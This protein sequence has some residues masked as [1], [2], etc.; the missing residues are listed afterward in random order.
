MLLQELINRV[1][2]LL[3][4]RL[5]AQ[6]RT[7]YIAR[8]QGS[9]HAASLDTNALGLWALVESRRY[10]D[11]PLLEKLANYVADGNEGRGLRTHHSG[12]TK[13]SVY[14]MLALRQYDVARASA[15]PRLELT[16]TETGSGSVLLRQQF[17]AAGLPPVRYRS[18]W[19]AFA[20]PQDPNLEFRAVGAGEASV[21]VALEFVPKQT[22]ASP[23]YLGL[24]VEK[25]IVVLNGTDGTGVPYAPETRLRPGASPSRPS[26]P[27]V[28]AP[29]AL[30]VPRDAAGFAAP[31]GLPP[32]GAST[33]PSSSPWS[34]TKG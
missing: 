7:A 24:Y 6:G 16:V 20:G 13:A 19:D 9:A 32:I 30:D 4:T 17:D 2:E 3:Y 5:R 23:V 34:S 22:F 28:V 33:P 18:R 14:R 1:A 27:S 25:V 15:K 11:E 12:S 31:R 29:F 21:T 26:S 10:T 8:E